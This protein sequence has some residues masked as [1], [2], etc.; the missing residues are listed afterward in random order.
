MNG[1][2][3]LDNRE[4]REEE[5]DYEF[6][7]LEIEQ[8]IIICQTSRCVIEVSQFLLEIKLRNFWK[9]ERLKS[10]RLFIKSKGKVQL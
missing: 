2:P 10:E 1:E 7:Y 5:I 3:V 6:P 8:I 9:C 4:A